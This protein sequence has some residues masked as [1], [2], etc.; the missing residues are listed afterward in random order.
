MIEPLFRS[1]RL[2]VR[3]V[4]AGDGRWQVVTFDPYHS[5]LGTDRP[6]FGESYFQEQGITAV[7]VL[8]HGNNWF[9][10]AEI[11]EV[12]D[13]IRDR[14]AGTER[15]LAYGSSMGGYAALRFGHAIGAHAVLALSPQY[16]VDPRKVPFET[17]W[18]QE[19]RRIRF[20]PAI[21]DVIRPVPSMVVAFDPR[22]HFDRLQVDAIPAEA[23]IESVPLPHA[24]HPCGPFLSDIRLLHPLV[25]TVLDGTF[26]RARFLHAAHRRRR[27][28]PNFLTELAL[29]Q[30]AHRIGTAIA[31]AGK[32]VE[33]AP[34]GPSFRDVHARLLSTAGHHAEAIAQHEHAIAL[35]PVADYH[36][37]LSRALLAAGD[38][39][40]ALRV[41]RV[42]QEEA[43][44]RAGC[45][46]WAAKLQSLMGDMEGE[47]ADL[48]RAAA[49]DPRNSSYRF[50]IRKRGWQL[51]WSRLL[52]LLGGRSGAPAA[53]R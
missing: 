35:E 21:E 11:A 28:S 24:G 27:S 36:W 29:R 14:C 39:A 13:L 10:Y 51:R 8:S 31:L 6:G 40:G 47:I 2:H 44:H 20:L 19:Q 9:Q 26:D 48:R 4:A 33:Q 15:L 1:D 17:R 45:H 34:T 18:G 41:A 22:L 50:T 3:R 52:R 12:L 16:S 7:H 49:L 43:P 53:R 25:M 37:G 32:A 38:M 46:A 42:L 23:P 5:Q 30:P